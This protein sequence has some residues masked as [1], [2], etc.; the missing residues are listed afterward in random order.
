MRV[1]SPPLSFVC[2]GN[3]S[4]ACVVNLL[5]AAIRWALWKWHSRV[6]NSYSLMLSRGH[7]ENSTQVYVIMK[8]VLPSSSV[9]LA[10][11]TIVSHEILYCHLADILGITSKC[12]SEKVIQCR[13]GGH[14]P[15]NTWVY[16][17]KSCYCCH[18]VCIL[19]VAAGCMSAWEV[20]F[21][22]LSCFHLRYSTLVGVSSKL[23]STSI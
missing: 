9:H 15:R 6:C 3:K 21:L 5:S 22:L 14:L 10:N 13:H 4:P 23:S 7:V 1:F 19:G 16:V 18:P 8:N 20:I 2:R 17:M 12:I 11:N